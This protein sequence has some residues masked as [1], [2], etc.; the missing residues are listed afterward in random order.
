M[1]FYLML[2][3]TICNVIYFDTQIV[4]DLDSTV[5]APSNWLQ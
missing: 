4:L 5:G 3:I 1:D 2:R